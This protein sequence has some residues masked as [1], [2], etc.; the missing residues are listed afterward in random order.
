MTYGQDYGQPGQYPQPGYGQ[1][2]RPEDQPWQHDPRQHQHRPSGPPEPP[3]QQAPD[4]PQDYPPRN[5]W[6]PQQPPQDYGQFQ[7][8]QRHHRKR[9]RAP[10]YAG[11]AAL[12]VIAA[13]GTVYAL[14]RHTASVHAQKPTVGWVRSDLKPVT[15][16]E[17]AGG[18]LVF[19]V[20]AGGGLQVAA[21]DPMTGRTVWHDS[22]SPG[23]TTPGVPPALGVAGSTVVFL[24]S[25]DNNVGSSQVV[26]VD[27]AT[28]RQLWHTP[29]GAF[30]DWPGPCP[31]DPLDIC[32]SGSLGQAGQTQA[33]RFRADDGAPAGA[34]LVSRSPGGRG[35]GPDLFDPGTRSPEMLLAVSGASV[36]WTRTLASVFPPPG[37][38]SSYGWNFDRVP[39]AGLFVGSVAGTPVSSTDS[40]ATID[41][42]RTM[43]AGFRI[44]D[45]TAVW[46]DAGSIYAC[47]QPLP[48][49]G[50][51]RM[52]E[53]GLADRA[54]G[55][56]LR[57]RA[58]GTARSSLSSTTPSL[59]PGADVVV[60]G[61]DLATGKTLWS[62]DAGRDG[63]LLTQTP[64]RLGSY[65]VALP[66]PSGGTVALNLATGAHRPLLPGAVGWCQSVIIYKTQVGWDT[67]GKIQY[68]RLGQQAIK[69]C[70]VSG[71]P[72]AIPQT[73]PGFVGT[74]VGG[75]TVWSE[76][77]E[78]A[79]AP[80]SS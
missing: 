33:L 2:H 77:S 6:Q 36:A 80:T 35:L 64:P 30:D 73:V 78:V 18:V 9:S 5:Q 47:N 10:L 40:S 17:L 32:A 23:D 48:C 50:G 74:V 79:A 12:I 57:L 11:I 70:R 24:R 19:Y 53:E 72:V 51:P 22:A 65:M 67:N 58:T 49:P 39:A 69:P 20:E 27:A 31:D 43:T 54:P 21:L 62:Y 8:R 42:S 63:P 52:A 46:R 41:L 60:E 37:L 75:L 71:T 38:S 28:G 14:A 25:V 66:A 55:T 15:Q 45:G 26:G 56:G 61:F 76:S 29:A 34:A 3:W 13:G 7:P 44:S 59:S 4:P 68:A 16:P 1:Q